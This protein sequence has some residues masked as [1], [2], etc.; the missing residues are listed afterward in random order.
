ML[1]VAFGVR[2]RRGAGPGTGLCVWRCAVSPVPAVPPAAA[3]CSEGPSDGGR[4][5][6]QRVGM[7][8][9][10][11]R[12]PELTGEVCRQEKWESRAWSP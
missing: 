12:R 6:S 5:L 1:P 9:R 11:L 4:G 2:S 7:G 8:G 10:R 3:R